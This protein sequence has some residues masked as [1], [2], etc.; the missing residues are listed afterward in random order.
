MS[1][2]NGQLTKDKVLEA[3]R[4]VKD[5]ELKK[6]LVELGM[7]RDIEIN[8]GEGAVKVT[9]ALTFSGCPLKRQ[10]KDEVKSAIDS[11]EGVRYS[12]VALTSMTS[13]ERA[14]LFGQ[15]PSDMEGI[16]HVRRIIAIASG[17]GGVGKSTVTVNLAIALNNLGKTT[18]ILDADFHGPDIPIMMG[19]DER[20]VGSKGMLIPLEKY[21]VKLMSTATLAGEGVPI[22]WRGPLV[23]KAVKEFLGKVKWGELDYLIVDLPPGTGD[24]TITV[25]KSIPLDG[26]I[27]VTTPQKVAI[28]D[29][30]RAIGL[31]KT[32]EIPIL[33]IVEN[34][35]YLKLPDTDDIM[36]I[37]GSGGGEKLANAFNVPLLAQIP[38]EPS[39]RIGGDKGAPA[40]LQQNANS[41]EFY[42]LAENVM[43]GAS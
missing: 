14:R 10:I 19:V 18:G 27:V 39:I 12:E 40:A 30:R 36:D 8:S 16:K 29:V 3:L 41:Q 9:V 22:V 31:F 24:A 38:I 2:N 5:P 26:V 7:I 17:K 33:G 34:M 20:P 43:K 42:K 23:N 37:F 1:S 21:G 15:A 28:A 32:E 6:G 13:E 25:T 35:S 4:D 11:V